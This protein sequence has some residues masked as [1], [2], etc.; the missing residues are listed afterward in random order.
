M[1]GK[2]EGEKK[3]KREKKNGRFVVEKKNKFFCI[4]LSAFVST[5]DFWSERHTHD[6][7]FSTI[8][9]FI[10]K[11]FNFESR[12]N[13]NLLIKSIKIVGKNKIVNSF[14]KKFA[15]SSIRI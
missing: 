12:K 1:Y 6:Y 9:N 10:N 4:C 5:T 8:V 14:F 13:S 11:L 2:K 3:Q 7:F 15:D